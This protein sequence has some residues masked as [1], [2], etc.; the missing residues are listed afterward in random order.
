ML[1]TVETPF[2]TPATSPS[3]F[4]P[5]LTPM[6]SSPNCEGFDP[7]FESTSDAEFNKIRSSRPPKFKFLKDAEDKLNRR[8]LKE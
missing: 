8:K 7:L 1:L 3:Y 4:T 5:P 6:G 2:L